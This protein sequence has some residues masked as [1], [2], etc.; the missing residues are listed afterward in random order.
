M[1]RETLVFLRDLLLAQ[2]LQVGAPDYRV[3]VTKVN[4]ALDE[5]DM[6]IKSSQNSVSEYG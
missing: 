4:L 1:S 5:L 2:T 6:A 3:V